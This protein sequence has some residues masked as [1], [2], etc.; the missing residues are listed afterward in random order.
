METRF[1]YPAT[2]KQI[3]KETDKYIKYEIYYIIKILGISVF[4]IENTIDLAVNSCVKALNYYFINN[5]F[6]YPLNLDFS[7]IGNNIIILIPFDYNDT[8][9]E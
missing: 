9:K 8:R 1:Y 5:N 6:I 2:V 7:K 3:C 4:S